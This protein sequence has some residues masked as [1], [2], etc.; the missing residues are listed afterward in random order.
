MDKNTIFEKGC[1][2]VYFQTK[3]SQ[4]GKHFDGLRMKKMEYCMDI[5][6]TLRPFGILNGHLVI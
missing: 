2:M 1:Q 3:K 6:N 4:F 5:G